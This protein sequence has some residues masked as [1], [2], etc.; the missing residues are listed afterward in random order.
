MHKELKDA[1]TLKIFRFEGSGHR[2]GDLINYYIWS[3]ANG[4]I[5]LV[6]K[7]LRLLPRLLD[8]ERRLGY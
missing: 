4:L 5:I 8:A 7:S 3:I 1:P 2:F 6:L